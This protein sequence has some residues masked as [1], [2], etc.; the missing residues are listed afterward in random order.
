MKEIISIS[1]IKL[2]VDSFYDKVR[3]DELLADIFN[4]IIKE[5]W[6]KH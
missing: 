6:P 2:L 3:E 4:D 1:D 5:K